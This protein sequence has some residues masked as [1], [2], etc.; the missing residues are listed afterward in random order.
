[1]A[2]ITTFVKVMLNLNQSSSIEWWKKSFD[3][4]GVHTMDKLI[5]TDASWVSLLQTGQ[6]DLALA[7]TTSNMKCGKD[8]IVVEVGCG[9]GRIS[10]A[11]SD[12]FG[13]VVGLDVA[14]RLIEEARRCNDNDR[15]SFE[16]SDGI[17]LRPRS[18]TECDT[19]FAY[20]VF[21]YVSPEPLTTYFSDAY[22]LLVPG[23]QFVFQLNMEPISFKTHI[24]F[25]LRQGLYA[26]G[27]KHWRGWPTGAGLYRYCH[28]S[29]W[30]TAR[31]TRIGFQVERISGPSLRQKW[32]VA[33]KR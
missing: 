1:M 26:C 8:R 2:L 5:P 13:R 24:S 25:W 21:H 14:P 11:L 4:V 32:I 29:E 22:K 15:V 17:H 27:I 20:E 31:L 3:E 16:V 10:A 18:V 23:G 7:L 12:H 19:V 6:D 30:L 33:I 28:S 9:L